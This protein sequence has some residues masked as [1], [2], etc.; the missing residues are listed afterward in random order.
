[1]ARAVLLNQT[2][3]CSVSQTALTQVL[4]QSRHEPISIHTLVRTVNFRGIKNTTAIHQKKRCSRRRG[5]LGSQHARQGDFIH[6]VCRNALSKAP[7]LLLCSSAGGSD[8]GDSASLLQ[9]LLPLPLCVRSDVTVC[10]PRHPVFLSNIF[11]SL[12]ES[13]SLTR[14]IELERDFCH[15]A[16]LKVEGT[17]QS[18]K[19]LS[20][21]TC[22][23]VGAAG[24]L[25]FQPWS[26]A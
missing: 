12:Y 6:G 11:S 7:A 10:Q 25:P 1:M 4:L 5:G 22:T 19:A 2:S 17:E 13:P 26:S 8:G 21:T 3:I 24:A 18:G 15:F 20:K 16:L 14:G 9:T 23:N